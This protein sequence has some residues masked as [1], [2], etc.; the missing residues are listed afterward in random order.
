MMAS[1]PFTRNMIDVPD[2]VGDHNID[3]CDTDV[4]LSVRLPILRRLLCVSWS[5]SPLF[6]SEAH[7]IYS[8]CYGSSVSS[9]KSR[10][11]SGRTALETNGTPTSP[12]FLTSVQVAVHK[13]HEQSYTSQGSYSGTDITG[14]SHENPHEVTGVG[15]A[16]DHD[17]MESGS[18]NGA[19]EV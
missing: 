14:Q 3:C 15:L 6:G 2:S 12:A 10:P 4:S 13:V 18:K 7:C 11:K 1:H 17:S 8:I 5:L 16:G 19:E 9:Q